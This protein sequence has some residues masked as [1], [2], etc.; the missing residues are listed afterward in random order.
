MK[1]LPKTQKITIQTA[2]LV[3]LEVETLDKAAVV[4]GLK[5][6]EGESS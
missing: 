5:P 6:I 4:T 1:N 2:I 3:T